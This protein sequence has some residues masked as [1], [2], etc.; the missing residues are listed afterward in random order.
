M[1]TRNLFIGMLLMMSIWLGACGS[2]E[3]GLEETPTPASPPTT[4][5]PEATPTP[6]SNIPADAVAYTNSD[7]GFAMLL[8]AGWNVAGPLHATSQGFTFYTLGPTVNGEG[9]PD[10]SQIIVTDQLTLEQFVKSQCSVCPTQPVEDTTLGGSPA[11]RTRIGGGSAPEAEW[12]FVSQAGRLIGFS[13][14][15]LNGQAFDWVYSTI[16]FST[17]SITTYRDTSV[18]FEL[19]YP[20]GWVVD[21]TGISNGVILW[22]TKPEGPGSD[23]VPANVVKMDVVTMP[24]VSLT[25][26]ELVAQQKAEVANVNGSIL[27]EERLTLASGLEAV[28]LHTSSLGEAI[29][30]LAIINGHPVYVTGFGDISRFDEIARTLRPTKSGGPTKPLTFACSVAYSDG[31]RVYCLGEGGTPIAIAESGGQGTVR[32]PRI[33]PDGAWVAY[34]VSSNADISAEL[35]AVEVSTLTGPDGLNLPRRLLVGASQISSGQPEIVDSPKSYAWQAGTHTL[36]FNTRYMPAGGPTGPGEYTHNDLWKVNA[37]TGEVVN[38]LSRNSVGE[39][40][41]SPDGQQV[42][43]SNPQSIALLRADGTDFRLVLEFPAISTYSEYAYKPTLVWSPDSASFSLLVPSADPLAGDASANLYRVF[44]D[45]EIQTLT[46]LTGNFLFSVQRNAGLSPNGQYLAYTPTA[47]DNILHLRVL[48]TDGSG[49]TALADDPTLNPLGWSPDSN[50]FVFSTASSGNYVAD[51]EGGPQLFGEGQQ[52]VE[53]KWVDASSFYFLGVNSA[54]E[55]GLYFYR[56]GATT[57]VVATGLNFDA[58]LDVR[59]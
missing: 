43:L 59:S 52:A 27:A 48:K 10:T 20:A 15:P 7:Y 23:G 4:M 28:R 19:D 53:L 55:W 39:F 38:I 3:I 13:V 45:G 36:Y 49:E 2:L 12:Y 34:L 46:T 41:L 33:S 9:G 44:A 57:Q 47:R 1:K 25:L 56:L 14:R 17:P 30:L 11:K 5:P 51:L 8:P 6:N 24:D 26:D 42:G 40:Y 35:W 31:T 32:Q 50:H 16:T 29:S 21:S 37:D 22:S 54:G 58:A 18:G